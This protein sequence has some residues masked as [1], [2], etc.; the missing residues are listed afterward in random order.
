MDNNQKNREK[1]TEISDDSRVEL[2]RSPDG[3]VINSLRNRDIIG[4]LKQRYEKLGLSAVDIYNKIC[5]I[6][7]EDAYSQFSS[8]E[9]WDPRKPNVVYETPEQAIVALKRGKYIDE[10]DKKY[11]EEKSAKNYHE[12]KFVDKEYK[13]LHFEDEQAFANVF[14]EEFSKQGFKYKNY[15]NPPE[16]EQELINLVLS[17]NP[18]LIIMYILMPKMDGFTAT[19]IL[20]GNPKTKNI[21]IIGLD[22]LSDKE[23]IDRTKEYGMVD[24]FLKQNV[25]I[26]EFIEKV[27]EYLNSP[28]S[29]KP[30]FGGGKNTKKLLEEIKTYQRE[31][32]NQ[33]NKRL[34]EYSQRQTFR[35]FLIIIILIPVI[36]VIG[37]V[38]LAIIKWSFQMVLLSKF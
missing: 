22:N 34:L 33:A 3:R 8:S 2:E 37:I 29:Y 7:G 5:D 21:P 25:H 12:N 11:L 13:I 26:D 10:L 19:K 20:K 4:E 36:V 17:E 1:E 30:V 24:Y 6:L 9:L 16:K 18:E 32:A 35:K 23:H 31:N 28:D 14:A 38:I 15:S 27:K